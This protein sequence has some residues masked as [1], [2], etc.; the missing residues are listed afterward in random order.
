M[1]EIL[2]LERILAQ[3]PRQ[4]QEPR[5][6]RRVPQSCAC[7]SSAEEKTVAVSRPKQVERV[8]GHKKV[9]LRASRT[10]TLKD[11]EKDDVCDRK[12]RLKNTLSVL[13]LTRRSMS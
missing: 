9:I 8:A 12:E 2:S 7:E 6:P 13:G 10:Y 11:E 3:A 5:R 4:A 1:R